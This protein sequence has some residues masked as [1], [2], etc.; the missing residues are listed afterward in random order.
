MTPPLLLVTLLPTVDLQ[1]CPELQVPASKWYAADDVKKK[2]VP[3]KHNPTKL[4]STIKPG[5]VLI[6][7]SGRFRGKRVVFLKQLPSGTLLVTGESRKLI[8]YAL[9]TGAV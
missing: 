4:R 1:H 9:F 2:K 5:T 8:R 7:L 3:Q 6:L